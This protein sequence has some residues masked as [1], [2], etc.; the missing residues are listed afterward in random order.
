M[1][2]VII[3]SRRE[4]AARNRPEVFTW[5]RIPASVEVLPLELRGMVQLREHVTG[6]ERL[7]AQGVPTG[8]RGFFFADVEGRRYWWV[9][10]RGAMLLCDGERL[11]AESH[12]G[13]EWDL[14]RAGFEHQGHTVLSKANE[15]PQY[16]LGVDVHSAVEMAAALENL[17]SKRNYVAQVDW[18]VL[19]KTDLSERAGK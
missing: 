1:V 8:V 7:D 15:A 5:E 10:S 6:V 11:K 19:D 17:R 2:S 16:L 9:G 18:V 12:F 3:D 14:M 4:R 13:L